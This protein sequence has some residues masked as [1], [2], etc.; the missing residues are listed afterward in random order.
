MLNLVGR[1][2]VKYDIAARTIC[3]SLTTAIANAL[4][5]DAILTQPHCINAL[6]IEALVC[7]PTMLTGTPALPAVQVQ[8]T[9]YACSHVA[10]QQ[11]DLFCL[12]LLFRS[13]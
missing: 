8:G 6:L 13:Y 10:N 9:F 1:K 7:L 12:L 2:A 3:D 5:Q 11:D 4:R